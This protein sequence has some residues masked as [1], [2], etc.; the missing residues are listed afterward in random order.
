MVGDRESGGPR[1]D[2][3][4]EALKDKEV[5]SPL[6]LGRLFCFQIQRFGLIFRKLR[7]D[8]TGAESHRAN[9]SGT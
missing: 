3:L 8:D 1:R 4:E 7:S 2:Q 5:C 9:I 6:K